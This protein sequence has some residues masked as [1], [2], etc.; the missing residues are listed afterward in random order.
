MDAVAN[1]PAPLK[2]TLGD[3]RGASVNQLDSEK[4][5]PMFS[6]ELFLEWRAPR[7]GVSNP[8]PMGN[9]VWDWLVRTKQSAYAANEL[10]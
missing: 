2:A 5:E 3:S 9:P 1:A 7:C 10:L 8:D 6:C 4:I